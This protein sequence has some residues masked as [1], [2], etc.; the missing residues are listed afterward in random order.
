MR[1]SPA[2]LRSDASDACATENAYWIAAPR[3]DTSS[4]GLALRVLHLGAIKIALATS[5]EPHHVVHESKVFLA[6]FEHF[7]DCL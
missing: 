2:F 7:Q 6:F 3:T 1:L 5:S 4:T